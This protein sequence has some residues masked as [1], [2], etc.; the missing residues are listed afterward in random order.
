MNEYESQMI[1]EHGGNRYRVPVQYDFSA[2]INPLGMPESAKRAFAGMTDLLEY[3]PDPGCYLLREAI[4]EWEQVPA[5]WILTGNGA[6][7]L[8]YGLVYAVKPKKALIV[9][10][11]FSEYEKALRNV[12]CEI[13]YHKLEEADGFRLKEEILG[14]ITE[15]TDLLFLCNPNNPTG[16]TISE[17]LLPAIAGRCEQNHTLLVVDECFLPFLCKEKERTMKPYLGRCSFLAVL[18]A[19][20]KVFAMPG[21]RLGYLLSGNDVL[22]E[23]VKKFLPEW[24]TS[25]VAQIVGREAVKEKGYLTRTRKLLEKERS[26]LQQELKDNPLIERWYGGEADFFFLKGYD[27]LY[28]KLLEQGILIRDCS[29]FPTLQ[30]GY[31]RIAVRTHQEN[32]QLVNVMQKLAE[33][34][35]NR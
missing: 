26:F 30:K 19:F 22:L 5:E 31:Y 7:E 25:Q 20:T 16:Q 27:L 8:I 23:K 33:E 15:E 14:A 4:G 3:Y 21:V 6:V 12:D 24:N 34:I 2:N 32:R 10:P 28:E 11:S 1:P 17:E 29:N 9:E 18:R 13:R 35:S